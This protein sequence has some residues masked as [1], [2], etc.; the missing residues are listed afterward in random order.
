M[1]RQLLHELPQIA[2]LCVAAARLKNDSL[3][4]V[5]QHR[6]CI[7]LNAS[8]HRD[9][10]RAQDV[11]DALNLQFLCLSFVDVTALC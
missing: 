1:T 6:T 11:P 5:M 2:A 4:R 7:A 9:N 3:H 8:R 10:T